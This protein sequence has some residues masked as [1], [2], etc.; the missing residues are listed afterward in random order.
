MIQAEN[1]FR[2]PEHK[3][4]SD[5]LSVLEGTGEGAQCHPKNA[6]ASKLSK[7]AIVVVR[8]RNGDRLSLIGDEYKIK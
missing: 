7:A 6:L 1:P 2:P 8:K 4:N 3:R 5:K